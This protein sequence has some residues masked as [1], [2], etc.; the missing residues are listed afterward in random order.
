MEIT[1]ELLKFTENN[2]EKRFKFSIQQSHFMFRKK[3]TFTHTQNPIM[4]EIAMVHFYH[5][6]KSYENF[7]NLPNPITHLIVSLF[8]KIMGK[9]LKH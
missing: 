8:K 6:N 3:N 1:N 4:L 5:F 2:Y 7:P 9:K